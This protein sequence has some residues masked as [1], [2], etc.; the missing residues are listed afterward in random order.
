MQKLLLC[1]RRP[2]E[3]TSRGHPT[4]YHPSVPEKVGRIVYY[5]SILSSTYSLCDTR[6]GRDH[7]GHHTVRNT[8]PWFTGW[9]VSNVAMKGLAWNDGSMYLAFQ[10][11]G[12]TSSR[13]TW[14]GSVLKSVNS[15]FSR[16][17]RILPN[18]L[19]LT[20][21]PPDCTAVPNTWSPDPS[22]SAQPY[23]DTGLYFPLTLAWE[24]WSTFLN[25]QL[26][27][28]RSLTE[29][30]SAYDHTTGRHSL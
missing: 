5:S 2:V 18:F 14:F 21:V 11:S 8:R 27:V 4:L 16:S 20:G 1:S 7:S 3:E 28:R 23:L 12:Y 29:I 19:R 30:W 17:L 13:F 10:I 22:S 15:P 26:I 6:K 24:Y 25:T 9:F